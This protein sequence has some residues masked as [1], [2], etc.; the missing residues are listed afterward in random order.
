MFPP[1]R[2]IG[3]EQSI[4]RDGRKV[5]VLQRPLALTFRAP[6]KDRTNVG[7]VADEV[8]RWSRNRELHDVTV[9]TPGCRKKLQRVATDRS[10]RR[11][12]LAAARARRRDW[13]S[14]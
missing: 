6:D 3:C 5:V 7:R 1:R 14:P 12:H 4:T 13:S 11:H 8:R 2:V 9:A 10:N